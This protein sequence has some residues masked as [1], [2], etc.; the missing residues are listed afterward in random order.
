MRVRVDVDLELVEDVAARA[1]F[2]ARQDTTP[3]RFGI[4]PREMFSATVSVRGVLEL[5]EDDRDAQ[6]ARL[7]RREDRDTRRRRPDQLAAVGLVVT[8]DDLD[9]GRLAGAVL[10]EQGEDGTTGGV[11]VHTVEDLDA[12]EGLAD[13]ASLELEAS[14]ALVVTSVSLDRLG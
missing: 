12:A 1:A 4:R 13:L 3:R 11:E 14:S 10:P 7:A 2:I 8:G 9:E 6:V 5:L